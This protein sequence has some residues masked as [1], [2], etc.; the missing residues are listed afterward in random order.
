ML[1]IKGANIH[2]EKDFALRMA[3]YN[4]HIDIVKILL[5]H[6]ADIH[7]YDNSALRWSAKNGHMNIVNMLLEK[8]ADIH[9]NND[10]ALRLSIE[11]QHIDVAKLLIENGADKSV[12]TSSQLD[13]IL[14]SKIRPV[15]ML[16]VDMC[17]I[18]NDMA[19]EYCQYDCGHISCD[20]CRNKL[21]GKFNTCF[22]C[23]QNINYDQ[24]TIVLAAHR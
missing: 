10:Q 8:G 22:Y 5:D 15:A 7:A 14:R 4:G 13:M 12:L 17:A 19:Q 18:C 2:A 23:R 24:Y 20:D 6:G 21:I 16:E 9:A 1:L 3:S 11:C